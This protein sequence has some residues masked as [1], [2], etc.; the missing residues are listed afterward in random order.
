[1]GRDPQNELLRLGFTGEELERLSRSGWKAE[2][3]LDEVRGF[4]DAN[5]TTEKYA[6]STFFEAYPDLINGGAQKT[7]FQAVPASSFGESKTRFIWYPYIPI[8]DFTV[9]MASGGTGKTILNCG[10]AADVSNGFALP[11][12]MKPPEGARRVLIISAEDR[13]ELLRTR[14]QASDANLDNVF[15]ID[16]MQSVGMNFTTGYDAFRETIFSCLPALVVI[17]PWHAFLGENVN[18]DRAN[19]VRPV[20]QRLANLAKEADCGMILVSHVNKRTQPENANNAATGSADFINASRSAMSL[21]FDSNDENSRIVVHTKSN[22][23]PAGKSV[24]F[25][26]NG[27]GGL[28]WNGFSDITRETMEE[29]ARKRKTPAELLLEKA[30]REEARGLLL[31]ALTDA[32]SNPFEN[33]IRF[34]YDSFREQYGDVFTTGQP[35]RELDSLSGILRGK[36]YILTTGIQVRNGKEKG[37]GF[38]LKKRDSK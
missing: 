32:V 23:A 34:T 12:D 27:D 36:G 17:D 5:L 7:I 26:I 37:N 3:I 19:A 2:R 1:M 30:E 38:S 6:A 8:G 11:G 15:I 10:I 16:C 33:T 9:L 31:D 24:R 14:L 20:F 25:N 21:I 28:Y 4:L 29:A 22:Y 18:I 35:K 13:G